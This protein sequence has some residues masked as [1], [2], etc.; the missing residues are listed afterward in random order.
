MPKP[1]NVTKAFLQEI[2][3]DSSGAV[4]HEGQTIPVQFNPETLKVTL[5][6]QISGGDQSGGAA[7]Q[8]SGKGTTKLGF[9]LWFDVTAPSPNEQTETDVR[10]L[11][12]QVMDFMQANA[13]GEGEDQTFVPP[14]VRF[15]W[16]TF[17]FEGVMVSVTETLEYFST[18]GV[19]L[20]A[21]LTVGMT[22]QDVEVDFAQ[23]Q[24]SGS[25][26]RNPGTNRRTQSRDGDSVQSIAARSGNAEGWQTLA[27][28]NGIDN[29]RFVP[30]GTLL[31]M[32]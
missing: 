20:R 32:S 25:N 18:D 5:T 15:Q 19:P 2:G 22:K 28:N 3:W 8:F 11:T 24:R 6:N 29:P 23:A 4:N 12:K 7:I 1:A 16:G 21:K 17:K 13:Q 14:G 31:K 26:S 10:R 30:P 9:D 27:L